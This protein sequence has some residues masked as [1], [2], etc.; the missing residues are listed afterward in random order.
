MMD[1]LTIEKRSAN[2]RRIKSKDTS[3]ELI[4]RKIIHKMGYRFRLHRK[5]LPGKPDLTF[6]SKKKVVFVHGCFWHQHENCEISRIPKSNRQ[7]WVPKLRRN[8]FRD[9]EHQNSL[10]KLGW[11]VL[12]IWECEIKELNKMN[13]K[14]INFLL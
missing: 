9:Q 14:I 1:N 8:K 5:D 2:M 4:V 12:V 3:P 13:K 7:Y 11:K 10:K 6:P